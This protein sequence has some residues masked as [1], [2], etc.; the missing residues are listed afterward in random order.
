MN[1][2]YVTYRNLQI[3]VPENRLANGPT[4]GGIN[5]YYMNSTQIEDVIVAPDHS[6][7]NIPKPT[8]EIAGIIINQTG[9]G[10]YNHVHAAVVMGFKYGFVSADHVD[11]SD[12]F[13][14]AC[15]FPFTYPISAYAGTAWH[16]TA[17]WCPHYIY[18]P[19]STI[20]GYIAPGLAYVKIGL[21]NIEDL[22]IASNPWT[23]YVDFINDSSNQLTGEIGYYFLQGHNPDFSKNGGTNVL[24]T[25]LGSFGARTGTNNTN[26]TFPL[27]DYDNSTVGIDMYFNRKLTGGTRL[28]FQAAP[29]LQ[30]EFMMPM[31]HHISA[32][33]EPQAGI[34]FIF[35]TH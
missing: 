10:E 27:G 3:Y 29:I 35:M 32:R 1:T 17:H 31:S 23:A 16:L 13:G 30:M 22:T 20:C 26:I 25:Q 14:I 9:T 6:V 8:S 21:I 28:H 2:S 18:C 7:F 4:I 19:V 34:N 12:C 33:R 11:M 15:Q 24:A 5:D